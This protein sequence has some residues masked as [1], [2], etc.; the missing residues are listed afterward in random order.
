MKNIVKKGFSLIELLVV[1]AII[2][3]LAG[4]AIVGYNSYVDSASSSV[5]EANAN[6]LSRKIAAEKATIVDF[7]K[8]GTNAVTTAT[9]SD[10]AAKFVLAARTYAGTISIT[11]AAA[12]TETTASGNCANDNSINV[13]ANGASVRVCFKK[14]TE[15]AKEIKAW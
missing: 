12:T 3:I 6:Q 5:A 15:D 10:N 11:L 13:Y 14:G 2:G 9:T 4:I 1:V 7:P 8:T